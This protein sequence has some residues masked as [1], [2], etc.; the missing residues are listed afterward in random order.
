MSRSTL[1]D[2]FLTICH[3]CLRGVP[4]WLA[5]QKAVWDPQVSFY[6]LPFI[7]LLGSSLILQLADGEQP[8]PSPASLT[9]SL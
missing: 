7:F 6:P 3:F 8:P 5:T 9:A 4:P 1:R 2:G